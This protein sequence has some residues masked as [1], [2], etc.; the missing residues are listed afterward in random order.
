MYIHE[1][2]FVSVLGDRL[3]LDKMYLPQLNFTL[4][5]DLNLIS[6]TRLTSKLQRY[7]WR[8]TCFC[9]YS[10]KVKDACL[11]HPNCV[12]D[13]FFHETISAASY[14]VL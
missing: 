5:L 14:K 1:L 13:I 12:A 3:E 2:V 4:L 10:T 7:N 11:S 9:S 8:S 6:L